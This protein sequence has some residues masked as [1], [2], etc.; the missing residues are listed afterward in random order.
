MVH[1]IR[2][3]DRRTVR[4]PRL[5]VVLLRRGPLAH[6]SFAIE[7]PKLAE[8]YLLDIAANAPLRETQRHPRLEPPDHSRFHLGVLIK[9]VIQSVGKCRSEEHTSELQSL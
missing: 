1:R 7:G 8:V 5:L 2:G 3:R 6:R 4:S 9:V